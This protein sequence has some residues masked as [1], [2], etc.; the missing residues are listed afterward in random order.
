[1]RQSDQR[2]DIIDVNGMRTPHFPYATENTVKLLLLDISTHRQVQKVDVTETQCQCYPMVSAP[3]LFP[4]RLN[5]Q[6]PARA[7]MDLNQPELGI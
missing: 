5:G 7:L 4:W 2:P 3:L 6:E 1:M